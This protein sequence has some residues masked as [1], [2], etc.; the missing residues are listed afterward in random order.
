MLPPSRKLQLDCRDRSFGGSEEANVDF[1]FD[2]A[3]AL[4]KA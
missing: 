4:K 1:F 2:E 3:I